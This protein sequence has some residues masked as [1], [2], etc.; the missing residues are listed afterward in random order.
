MFSLARAGPPYCGVGIVPGVRVA[1]SG[2][3]EGGQPP[4]RVD[5]DETPAAEDVPTGRKPAAVEPAVK[6]YSTLRAP[7]MYR[8]LDFH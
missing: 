3:N 8:E 4:A 5:D 2:G 1:S 6:A 7:V